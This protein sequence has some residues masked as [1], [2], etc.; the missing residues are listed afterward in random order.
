M[1]YICWQTGRRGGARGE[2]LGIWDASVLGTGKRARVHG[3]VNT[4]IYRGGMNSMSVVN[5][6]LYS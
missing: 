2:R 4:Y 1:P 3:Q 6:K 5:G